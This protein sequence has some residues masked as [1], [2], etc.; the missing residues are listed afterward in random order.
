MALK[1]DY[2]A[3]QTEQELKNAVDTIGKQIIEYM[4]FAGESF[5]TDRKSVV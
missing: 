3:S 1:S 4:Q 2:N 5:I